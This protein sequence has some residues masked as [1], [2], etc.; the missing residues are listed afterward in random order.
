MPTPDSSQDEG[1]T[2]PQLHR[3]TV[4][5]AGP[6]FPNLDYYD[7]FRYLNKLYIRVP[8][9]EVQIGKISGSVAVWM[10]GELT[11]FHHQ[12]ERSPQPNLTYASTFELLQELSARIGHYRVTVPGNLS[13]LFDYLIQEGLET[14]DLEYRR[15]DK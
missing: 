8:G 15:T 1:P 12:T 5:F 9:G 7:V 4:E 2:T 6:E 3:P 13:D 11:T 14:R 10:D